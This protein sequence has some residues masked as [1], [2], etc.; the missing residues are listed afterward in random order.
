M[1]QLGCVQRCRG[2]SRKKWKVIVLTPGKSDR[3]CKRMARQTV[4]EI[5]YFSKRLSSLANN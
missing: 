3:A 1:R 2:Y 4:E 5:L